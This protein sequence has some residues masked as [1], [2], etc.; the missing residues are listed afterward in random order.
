M[1][2]PGWRSFY[3]SLCGWLASAAHAQDPR[4]IVEQTRKVYAEMQ[5]Y[6]DVGAQ[7]R[8]GPIQRAYP[9]DSRRSFQTIFDRRAGYAFAFREEE[10]IRGRPWI[11]LKLAWRNSEGSF[12]FLGHPGE[13]RGGPV[14]ER[15]SSE[16]LSG[17]FA[18]TGCASNHLL[19]LLD[20]SLRYRGITPLAGNSF[21]YLGAELLEGIDCHRIRTH[22]AGS[23][24]ELWIGKS[25]FL[26]RQIHEF[27]AGTR[28]ENRYYDIRINEPISS[29][30]LRIDPQA[31]TGAE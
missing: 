7:M 2:H 22:V 18:V 8:D 6:Q 12:S 28:T 10:E 3:W 14:T 23:S 19:S 20:S 16:A 1:T 5:T 31:L 24:T 11:L 15:S 26:I 30:L 17:L 4:A 13:R 29:A 27:F 25:D 9:R 21:D